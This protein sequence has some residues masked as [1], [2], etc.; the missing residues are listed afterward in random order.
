MKYDVVKFLSFQIRDDSETVSV[1]DVLISI[2]I[3]LL[4]YEA[5]IL[6]EEKLFQNQLGHLGYDLQTFHRF[7]STNVYCEQCF[8]AGYTDEEKEQCKSFT[9][10]LCRTDQIVSVL[11][12]YSE[13]CITCKKPLFKLR[14]VTEQIPM[15]MSFT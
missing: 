14:N 8:P 13:P 11:A 9:R 12:L 10:V 5:F 1:H 15:S 2:N 4:E 3:Y 7:I 6:P